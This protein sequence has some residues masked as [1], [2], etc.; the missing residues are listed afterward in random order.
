LVWEDEITGET[1]AMAETRAIIQAE[2]EPID[3]SGCSTVP[4]GKNGPWPGIA[5]LPLMLLGLAVWRRK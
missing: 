2:G 4:V 3:S 1:N 5:I